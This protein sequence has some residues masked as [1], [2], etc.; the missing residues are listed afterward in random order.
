MTT[1]ITA[2]TKATIIS[3]LVDA[4]YKRLFVFPLFLLIPSKSE[5]RQKTPP[6]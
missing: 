5:V 2:A 1:I 3:K 6:A 4:Y